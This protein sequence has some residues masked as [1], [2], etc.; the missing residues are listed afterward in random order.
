MIGRMEH[1][2][3]TQGIAQTHASKGR[4]ARNAASGF[5]AVLD[6]ARTVAPSRGRG[7]GENPSPASPTALVPPTPGPG[8]VVLS[9]FNP[10]GLPIR[11]TPAPTAAE[12][13]A[14]PERWRGT[15]FDPALSL[16]QTVIRPY[17]E[18]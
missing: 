13:A 9:P 8:D 6:A 14:D 18:E 15:S 4:R 11:G 17:I 2:T 5:G 7:N 3:Q 1:N 12:V 16:G 10:L